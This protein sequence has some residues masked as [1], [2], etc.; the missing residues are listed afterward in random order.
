MVLGNLSLSWFDNRGENGHT[1]FMQSRYEKLKLE[2]SVLL[3]IIQTDI[4]VKKC[5][6][7]FLH[8]KQKYRPH[9]Q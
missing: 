1:V 3:S 5:E 8:E 4:N 9:N 2:S 7:K 6:N